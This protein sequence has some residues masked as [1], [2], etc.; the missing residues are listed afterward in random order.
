M[1]GIREAIAFGLQLNPLP[2][3][4][5]KLFVHY[6]NMAYNE[7][8]IN[9]FKETLVCGVIESHF[10]IDTQE[11]DNMRP[12]EDDDDTDDATLSIVVVDL[13]IFERELRCGDKTDRRH[14][15][16]GGVGG[17]GGVESGQSELD[18]AGSRGMCT[19]RIGIK[20]N[21]SSG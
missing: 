13:E 3:T 6:I 20:A 4:D 7:N 16:V 5:N 12:D 10:H 11:D 18:T 17:G 14:A 2:R 1:L 19:N 8:N 15:E 21:K 9:D